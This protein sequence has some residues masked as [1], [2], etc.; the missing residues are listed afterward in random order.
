MADKELTPEQKNAVERHEERAASLAG[1]VDP[2]RDPGGKVELEPPR[3]RVESLEP[4]QGVPGTRVLITGSGF[5]PTGSEVTF[6]GEKAKVEGI[7]SDRLIAFVPDLV[8]GRKKVKVQ[9][10][11]KSSREERTFEVTPPKKGRPE[12]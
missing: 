2:S 1:P 5:P 8:P 11:G 4:Q 10:N 6:D 9:A 3:P 12:V 7:D